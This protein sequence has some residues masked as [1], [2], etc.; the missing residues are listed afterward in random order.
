MW[1]GCLFCPWNKKATYIKIIK[2]F[3]KVKQFKKEYIT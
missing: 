1:K 3:Q 2:M